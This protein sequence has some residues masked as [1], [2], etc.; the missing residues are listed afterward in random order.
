MLTRLFGSFGVGPAITSSIATASWTVFP[1]GP[2]TSRNV[3]WSGN[4]PVDGINPNVGRM[5][6]SDAADAGLVMDNP[7]SSAIPTTAMLVATATP[8]PPL[9]PPG[10]RS[11]TYALCVAPSRLL[12]ECV[13]VR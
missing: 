8:E 4:T 9:D 11:H 13:P 5:P 7:V 1:N 2:T 12:V 6:T 10:T 3:P